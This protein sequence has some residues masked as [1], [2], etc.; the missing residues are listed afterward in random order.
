MSNKRRRKAVPL[1]RRLL[2]LRRKHYILNGPPVLATLELFFGAILQSRAPA[3]PIADAPPV[4]Q[5]GERAA[6][7][8]SLASTDRAAMPSPSTLCTGMGGPIRYRS[9]TRSEERIVTH[10]QISSG[11]SYANDGLPS[12]RSSSEKL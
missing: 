8:H 10:W 11:K 2:S 1:P 9:P 3:L 7:T 4:E 5:V 12:R 6:Q